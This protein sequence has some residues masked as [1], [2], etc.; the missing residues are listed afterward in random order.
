MI[1]T[2]G[3]LI[4]YRMVSQLGAGAFVDG[5]LST[6]Q[7]PRRQKSQSLEVN[8]K[9]RCSVINNPR[10]G[11]A[12]VLVLVSLLSLSVLVLH[13][14]ET[15]TRN[16]EDS[17]RL[18]LEY[19]AGMLA[20][21]GLELGIKALEEIR[22]HQAQLPV[23]L[24]NTTWNEYGL[25]INITSC[26]ARLPINALLAQGD[27]QEQ[28]QEAILDMFTA[29]GVPMEQMA[30]LLYWMGHPETVQDQSLVAALN[31]DY[32][33]A[34]LEYSAPARKLQKPEELLLIPGFED[35]SAAWIRQNFTVWGEQDRI[36]INSADRDIVLALIP[37]LRPYWSR[38]AELRREKRLTH[39]N[40]L[41]SGTSMSMSTYTHAL[42]FLIFEP[43][44][45]EIL[46]QVQLGSW[47]EK[48]RYIVQAAHSQSGSSARV[49]AKDLLRA[50][51]I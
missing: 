36:D 35:L 46:V 10:S 42:N 21:K 19:R 32:Y 1:I 43:E 3:K 14:T 12:L 51:E 47:Q 13:V 45:Y 20:G 33:T 16:H 28:L 48:H 25:Q 34:N 38:I 6:A 31:Y 27:D 17:S 29:R 30:H 11:A 44:Y 7:K 4:K 22:T 37:E 9:F 40:Q 24:W 15:T 18:T 23:H 26:A 8:H 5:K 2:K 49:L 41:L 50:G 39:P